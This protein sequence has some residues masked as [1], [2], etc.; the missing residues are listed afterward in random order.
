MRGRMVSAMLAFSMLLNTCASVGRPADEAAFRMEYA[1]KT[2][3]LTQEDLYSETLLVTM[4][5]GALSQAV[6]GFYLPGLVADLM[7]V[8]YYSEDFI[9]GS[10]A[11]MAREYNC[12][13]LLRHSDYWVILS[14]GLSDLESPLG[15]DRIHVLSERFINYADRV[16]NIKLISFIVKR[17]SSS[18]VGS[19]LTWLAFAKLILQGVFGIVPW[20][21]GALT[22]GLNWYV[23]RSLNKIVVRYYRAKAA[24]DCHAPSTSMNE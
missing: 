4:T 11:I 6:P 3:N 8:V 12:P 24:L 16:M 9:Y 21:G 18:Q 14:S 1:H 13:D 22:S 19:D 10:G 17:Y 23:F 15:L 7:M 2:A 20:V 5:F